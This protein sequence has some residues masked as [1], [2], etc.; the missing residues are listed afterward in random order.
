MA[1]RNFSHAFMSD[2]A[3]NSWAA[4]VFLPVLIAVICKRPPVQPSRVVAPVDVEAV[5]DDVL[6]ML[7]L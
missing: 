6:S 5:A 7:G 1:K 3:G 2:L 4:M